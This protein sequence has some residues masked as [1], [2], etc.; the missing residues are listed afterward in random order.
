MNLSWSCR[1]KGVRPR[2]VE[3]EYKHGVS[4]D[5]CRMASGSLVTVRCQQGPRA[6]YLPFKSACQIRFSIPSTSPLCRKAPAKLSWRTD[7]SV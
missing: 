7:D 2:A 1:A 3:E 6:I 4:I 5:G